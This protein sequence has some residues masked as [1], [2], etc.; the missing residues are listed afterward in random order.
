LSVKVVFVFRSISTEEIQE[1]VKLEKLGWKIK[2]NQIYSKLERIKFDLIKD[3][4]GVEQ[5]VK[6]ELKTK[7]RDFPSTVE[8][9]EL[10]NKLSYK[11][12]YLWYY[13]RFRLYFALE[14]QWIISKIVESESESASQVKV[15]SKSKIR[16]NSRINVEFVISETTQKIKNG[17]W[18]F[19]LTVCMVRWFKQLFKS[20]KNHSVMFLNHAQMENLIYDGNKDKSVVEN[21]YLGTYLESTAG[22]IYVMDEISSPELGKLRSNK[23]Y[24]K[25]PYKNR[26]SM[27]TEAVLFN[28]LLNFGIRSR[29]RQVTVEWKEYLEQVNSNQQ[30]S[31]FVKDVSRLMM[32]YQSASISYLFRYLSFVRF[33]KKNSKIQIVATVG[34]QDSIRK[35]IL[36]A[37]R[38]SNIKTAGIQHGTIYDNHIS[39]TYSAEELKYQPAPDHMLVWGEKWKENLIKFGNYSDSAIEVVGQLRTDVIPQLLKENNNDHGLFKVIF[40]SQPMPIFQDRIDVLRAVLKAASKFPQLELIIRPHPRETDDLFFNRIAKEEGVTS[41]SIERKEGLYQTMAKSNALITCFSSVAYEALYFDLPIL[42]FDPRSEDRLS[43]IKNELCFHVTDEISLTKVF[44]ELITHQP[45][46]PSSSVKEFTKTYTHL[47][48]G[49]VVSRIKK[50]TEDQVS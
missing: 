12:F 20:K 17:S 30:Y 43:M 5:T 23:R 16:I 18:F 25:Y 8:G 48:D 39:Y 19:Y 10:I 26:D 37:A 6:S 27:Y 15:Y 22:D 46:V 31:P 2:S 4:W 3:Y 11:N 49:N 40:A 44:N 34:E 41:Y 7:L 50:F 33:F 47:V 38:F 9:E 24:W 45:H 32:A 28:G 13:H 1:L 42:I 36:D 14:S 29:T 35:A 21:T